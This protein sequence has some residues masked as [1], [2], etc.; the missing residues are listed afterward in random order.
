VLACI[1]HTARYHNSE[2]R[3]PKGVFAA[4]GLRFLLWYFSLSDLP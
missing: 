1:Y 4:G 2:I 3:N